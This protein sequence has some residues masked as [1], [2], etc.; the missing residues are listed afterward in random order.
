MEEIQQSDWVIPIHLQDVPEHQRWKNN[1][2]FLGRP[3][4]L[5][6][7]KCT[8]PD[9]FTITSEQV[10]SSANKCCASITLNTMC[11]DPDDQMRLLSQYQACPQVLQKE[12]HHIESSNSNAQN[13]PFT[14]IQEY[15]HVQ[16][17]YFWIQEWILA[18]EV[19][20][21]QVLHNLAK[22]TSNNTHNPESSTM[23]D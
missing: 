9:L 15:P 2:Y 16:I 14:W 17:G 20:C 11:Q 19:F 22:K 1:P 10:N 7:Q 13:N 23:L 6:V 3:E 5:L 4:L 18:G 12:G 21:L 8:R